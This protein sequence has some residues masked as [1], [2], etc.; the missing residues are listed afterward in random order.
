MLPSIAFASL[1][2][3]CHRVV[4]FF[5]FALYYF[6]YLLSGCFSCY[7]LCLR[8]PGLVPAMCARGRAL[9]GFS[10]TPCPTVALVKKS[11]V[12]SR[13]LH[14]ELSELVLKA[15]R[16]QFALFNFCHQLI[17]LKLSEL[18]GLNCHPFCWGML[19]R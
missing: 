17:T 4:T 2:L 5:L 1:S 12:C 8:R 19:E 3:C 11:S 16:L 10:G 18:I 6:A 15:L 7:L 14:R 9:A 13:A